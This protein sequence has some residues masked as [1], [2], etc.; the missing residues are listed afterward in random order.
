MV[1]VFASDITPESSNENTIPGFEHG[2]KPWLLTIK[3][4][5]RGL[6]GSAAWRW[7]ELQFAYFS[8]DGCHSEGGMTLL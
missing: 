7:I 6:W 8:D 1:S 2:K 4:S 3:E 5:E